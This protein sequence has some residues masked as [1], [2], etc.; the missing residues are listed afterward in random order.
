MDKFSR[1]SAVSLTTGKQKV[2]LKIDGSSLEQPRALYFDPV[3]RLV[4][5]AYQSAIDS[6]I[7]PVL[8]AVRA[9]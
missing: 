2:L 7:D 1:L 9:R 3:S 6:I 8:Q 4:L 5:L